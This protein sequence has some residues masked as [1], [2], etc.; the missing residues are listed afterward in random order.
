[1]LTNQSIIARER[2]FLLEHSKIQQYLRKYCGYKIYHHSVQR[3][4]QLSNL[5][6]I[7]TWVK[8]IELSY[9]ESCISRVIHVCSDWQ[10]YGSTS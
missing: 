4:L 8:Y 9:D 7:F 2:Y 5:A 6:L 10:V 1:M 3:C